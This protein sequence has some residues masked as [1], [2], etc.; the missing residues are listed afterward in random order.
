MD[1]TY[2][3]LVVGAGPGGCSAAWRL[4]GGGLRVLVVDR[5]SFP[6]EK[7][8]GD[9]IAPRAVH[10]L[11]DMG[12]RDR[13]QG[14]FQVIRG[15]RF[16][17][18][19][20]GLT[21]VRYPMGGHFPDHAY[22]V[23][24]RELDHM[25]VRK[26]REAGVE[27]REGCEVLSPLPARR[28]RTPG[29]LA[30]FRG[31]KLTLGARFVIAA[32]GPSSAVGNALGLLYHDP[33]YLGVSVRCYMRGAREVS[34]FLEIYPEDAIMP[35]CGW[36]FP[37][38]AETVNVGVGA[39]LYAIKRRGINLNRCFEDFCSKTRHA[40]P[41][42]REAEPLGRLRGAQLR[43]ALRGSRPGRGNVLLVGDAAS[44]TNPISGEGISYALESG[45]MAGEAVRR[46]LEEGREDALR[47]YAESLRARYS[48]YF[49]NGWLCIRFGNN[50]WVMN[51]LIRVTSKSERLGNK[52]GRYLMNVR[53]SDRPT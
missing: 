49:R 19:R 7:I 5:E 33:R 10:A 43:V 26:V 15:V 29:V 18:T 32:D 46:A 27:V 52:M 16:Y 41:K 35:C 11:Y 39:M 28:G 47:D 40:A 25:L 20:G 6:R 53:R 44:T 36:V 22:I 24:R 50:P 1:E 2:D 12:L 9:G 48:T 30:S 3:V 21:E 38:D 23:P 8:C 13:L 31:E 51:P 4:A 45:K 42:L 14:R 37:V 34:D 17:S